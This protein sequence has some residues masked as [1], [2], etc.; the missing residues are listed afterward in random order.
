M[1]VLAMD[2]GG[3]AVKSAIVDEN[4]TMFEF[5]ETPTAKVIWEG[6]VEIAKSYSGYEAIGISTAGIVD[7]RHGVVVFSSAA[8]GYT[9]NEPLAREVS[10]AVG[11]P[12]FVENDVNCAAMGEFA[13]GA[14]R[15]CSDFVCVT[16]GTSIGG[17]VFINGRLYR[18]T[19]NMAGEIGHFVTHAYGRPCPC[20]KQGC[21]SEYAS[22]TA[23]I[24]RAKV[25][26]PG[27]SDGRII[28]ASLD[29]PLLRQAVWDWA[30]E[31]G[32]G[33]ATVIHI[34][35]PKKVILGGG[36]M[37]DSIFVEVINERLPRHIMPSYS[38]VEVVAAETGNRAGILGAAAVA[39]NGMNE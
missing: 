6:I 24:E 18:G 22:A 1:R 34:F 15:G 12:V 9:D 10:E 21:Y 36:I 3:T 2:V 7:Y 17:A 37:N 38:Q 16:Y 14:G 11:V 32:I 23:L 26:N 5:R 31:V 28:A 35:D 13:F 4:G 33:I 19:R 29:N 39:I 8:L 27:Y 20:G 25:I 30:D